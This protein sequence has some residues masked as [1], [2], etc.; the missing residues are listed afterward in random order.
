[1]YFGRACCL[2]P[3][4][5]TRNGHRF[6][7]I[8]EYAG[9]VFRYL[10]FLFS[11]S[12]YTA[13]RLFSPI[14]AAHTLFSELSCIHSLLV[15]LIF[16]HSFPTRRSSDLVFG[17]SHNTRIRYFDTCAFYFRFL[18]T[19]PHDYFLQLSLLTH[20]LPNYHAFILFSST[21]FLA[22]LSHVSFPH[23]FRVLNCVF[24]C[25]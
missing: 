1:M 11:F 6:R 21:S 10:C 8:T 24:H 17:L 22:T 14:I 23:I 16:Y 5:K 9:Q 20:C 3:S 4:R 18:I 7:F 19:P 15:D 12:Y 13:P 25:L 2:L